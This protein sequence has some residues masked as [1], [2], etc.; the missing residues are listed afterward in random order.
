MKQMLSILMALIFV[1]SVIPGA[2]AKVRADVQITPIDTEGIESADADEQEPAKAEQRNI[3]REKL[4]EFAQD[5]KQAKQEFLKATKASKE[6][7][8]SFLDSRKQLK[9]CKDTESTECTALSGQVNQYAKDFVINGV[10]MAIDHL[11]QLKSKIEAAD[12]LDEAKAA[13][14]VADID[15]SIAELNGI[16]AKVNAAQTKA[17]I[18]E[19]TKELKQI[20]TKIRMREKVYATKLVHAKVWNI[21][22]RAETL[23]ARL[24]KVLARMEAK[25]IQVDD[26][27]TKLDQFNAKISDAKAKYAEAESLIGQ[28]YDSRIEETKNNEVM[29][30]IKSARELLRAAHEDIKEAHSILISIVQSVKTKGGDLSDETSKNET[31][32]IEEPETEDESES[33]NETEESE[34]VEESETEKQE[35]SEEESTVGED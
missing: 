8:Q 17:E 32:E 19:A 11:T 9:D 35:E 23:E 30:Q 33:E 28:A 22:H 5:F 18:K 27:Q 13:E 25:G 16:I 3:N 34:E 6:S 10:Q 14:I 7:R 20:W 31:G 1:L 29:T 4:K 21:I 26:L 12:V 15:N 24:D 2:M